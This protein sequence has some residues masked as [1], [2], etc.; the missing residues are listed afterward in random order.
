MIS[1]IKTKSTRKG[2]RFSIKKLQ[3]GNRHR[4]LGEYVN[5]SPDV[6]ADIRKIL[7]SL[8]GRPSKTIKTYGG[9]VKVFL[10]DNGVKAQTQYKKPS[11]PQM[12]PLLDYVDI[13]LERVS[14]F[15]VSSRE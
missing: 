7:L 4:R 10:H 13:K 8:E 14:L 1:R 9:A 5:D 11:K 6:V 15:L 3:E 12:K 2:V